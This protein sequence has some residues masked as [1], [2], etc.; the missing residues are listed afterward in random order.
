[1]LVV[2]VPVATTLVTATFITTLLLYNYIV[3]IQQLENMLSYMHV[4]VHAQCHIS[5]YIPVIQS[6]FSTNTHLVPT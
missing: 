1:M 6:L 4:H 2:S 3:H 5:M